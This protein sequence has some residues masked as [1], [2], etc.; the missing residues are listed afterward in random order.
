M[1]DHLFSAAE[2]SRCAKGLLANAYPFFDG[3]ILLTARDKD[4]FTRSRNIKLM[5]IQN[6]T[7]TADGKSAPWPAAHG[8]LADV[9]FNMFA[10]KKHNDVICVFIPDPVDHPGKP[11]RWMIE[12]LNLFHA[13][14]ELEHDDEDFVTSWKAARAD[15]DLN[16]SQETAIAWATACASW[17]DNSN[18]QQ[19]A[20]ALVEMASGGAGGGVRR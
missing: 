11:A 14:R 10:D 1:G 3:A 20:F 9:F 19:H 5:M 12:A 16:Q 6:P 7:R 15:F 8:V 2:L 13:V 18:G 17:M 4:D